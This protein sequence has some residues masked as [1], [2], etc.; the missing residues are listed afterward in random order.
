[1]DKDFFSIPGAIAGENLSSDQFRFVLMNAT[2]YQ[3]AGMTNA[4]AERPIGILQNDPTVAGQAAEVAYSGAC[5]V[6]YG[7]NVTPGDT[8][9]SDNDGKAIKDV[10]VTDGTAHDVHHMATALVTGVSG[11]VEI[12]LLHTPHLIGK[13]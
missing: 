4:N 2:D 3:V 6:E 9:I 7:G 5:K 11:D 8:L 12:V 1:M 13:E 10:E